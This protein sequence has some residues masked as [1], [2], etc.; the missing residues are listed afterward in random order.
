MKTLN[1]KK[2]CKV[3]LSALALTGLALTTQ[4][5]MYQWTFDGGSGTTVTP[6]VATGGGGGLTMNYGGTATDLYGAAGSGVSGAAG[7]LAFANNNTTYGT[8]ASSGLASSTTGN[9]NIGVQTAFTMTGWIKA[10]GGFTTIGGLPSGSTFQRVFMIGQGTPDTGSA[11][12]ATLSLF[13]N[14]LSPSGQTNALQLKLGNAAGYIGG[15]PFGADGALSGNGSLNAFGSAWTFF[16]V[17]VDLTGTANNVNFYFGNAAALNAP[18]TVTYTNNVGAAIGS[19]DF[20]N[21]GSALLLNRANEARGFDGW[22]DDFAFYSGALDQ[23]TVDGIRLQGVP[24]PATVTMLALGSVV[25]VIMLR[26][27]NS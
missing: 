7:D 14:S 6:S 26:R 8:A 13:N 1:Y 24:E 12:S 23:T 21:T 18:I 27:R 19:I 22:G 15:A 10:D 16:A 9:I 4:A 5:Q 2:S 17:T 25:G 3:I 20:G 11:N